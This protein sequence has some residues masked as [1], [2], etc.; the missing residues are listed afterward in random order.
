MSKA[1]KPKKKQQ[2]RNEKLILLERP[3]THA[4][5]QRRKHWCSQPK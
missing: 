2:K 3:R 1:A 4:Y 5:S